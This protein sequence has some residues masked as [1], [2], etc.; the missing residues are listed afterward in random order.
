[1]KK[2]NTGGGADSNAIRFGDIPENFTASGT[3]GNGHRTKDG[4]EHTYVTLP[5]EDIKSFIKEEIRKAEE[6][7]REAECERWLKASQK[8]NEQ[9]KISS[10]EALK[11]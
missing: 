10:L 1:M 9:S 3:S 4:K 6:R 7:G 8:L 11:K 2:N 5:L